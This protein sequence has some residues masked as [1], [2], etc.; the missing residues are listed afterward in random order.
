MIPPVSL[1]S[2]LSRIWMLRRTHNLTRF[3]QIHGRQCSTEA[4]RNFG[5]RCDSFDWN[6]RPTGSLKRL[7]IR[8]ALAFVFDR[9][10]TIHWLLAVTT[11]FWYCY[12]EISAT[13]KGVY[14]WFGATKSSEGLKNASISFQVEETN[15]WLF[16]IIFCK[17]FP[18]HGY[19]K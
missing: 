13:I 1:L 9:A 18:E 2:F 8:L 14:S 10:R 11:K 3:R 7:V 19:W 5:R 4:V 6:Q 17:S 15:K 12:Q 16:A